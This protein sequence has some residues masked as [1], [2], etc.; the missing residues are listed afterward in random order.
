MTGFDGFVV[1]AWMFALGWFLGAIHSQDHKEKTEGLGVTQKT[2]PCPD[3]GAW[4]RPV[5][6]GV[7]AD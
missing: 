6:A 1:G 4:P 7:A 5:S 3:C 2:E